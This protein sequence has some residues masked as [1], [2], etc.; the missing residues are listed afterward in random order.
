MAVRNL[1]AGAAALAQSQ[2]AKSLG[3]SAG[4]VQE[5]ARIQQ[6][7]VQKTNERRAVLRQDMNN[8]ANFITRMASL[9]KVSGQ[10]H[11]VLTKEAQ[12]TR[13][14]LNK[15]AAD[16]TLNSSEKIAEYSRLTD[17]YNALAASFSADQGKLS[18]FQANI[19]QG[20]TSEALNLADEDTAIARGLGTGN[21]EITKDGY[22]V[23][24][25]INGESKKMLV[26]SPDIDKYISKYSI[27]DL[28]GLTTLQ[29]NYVKEIANA[30]GDTQLE[31]II[32]KRFELLPVEDKLKLL[33][34]LGGN[35]YINY[36]DKETNELNVDYINAEFK[37][38]A[39][40]LTDQ[41]GYTPTPEEKQDL[42]SEM[43][44]KRAEDGI[45]NLQ[46]YGSYVGIKYAGYPITAM[47]IETNPDS[48]DLGRIKIIQRI[49]G[50]NVVTYRDADDVEFMRDMYTR[51]LLDQAEGKDER[52]RARVIANTYFDTFLE[53]NNEENQ[54]T[55]K[56]I[57][58][59]YEDDPKSL[60]E[61][62]KFFINNNKE[63]FPDIVE[64]Q[65]NLINTEKE[66]TT[67]KMSRP[68]KERLRENWLVKVKDGDFNKYLQ[69]N[70]IPKEGA[71]NEKTGMVKS[72][73]VNRP[74]FKEAFGNEYPANTYRDGSKLFGTMQSEFYGQD[75]VKTPGG[76]F[77]KR[78]RTEVEGEIESRRQ[79]LLGK[80]DKADRAKYFRKSSKDLSA[81]DQLA[82]NDENIPKLSAK[83]FESFIDTG[84]LDDKYINIILNNKD[85][86]SSTL[87][88][89]IQKNF[90]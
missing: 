48:E 62:D 71:I 36:I 56:D 77:T 72:T 52:N 3:F 16:K 14:A 34:D 57:N 49:G 13:D 41:F 22:N 81:Y 61:Q 39:A 67:T 37:K 79:E 54:E 5:A 51:K 85:K 1:I 26:K 10:Y 19:A 32:Q 70:N 59:K 24:Y 35:S 47:G 84:E 27:K 63:L 60:T 69:D 66:A 64:D 46:N 88:D 50:D 43:L 83:D 2:T 45:K 74:D 8:A 86:F 6:D 68:Q 87:I 80:A 78:T 53:I 23:S 89:L 15:I 25:D 33:V 90:K 76:R 11:N 18:E 21:Y 44:T 9:D 29:D 30:K 17:E 28:E 82:K 4:L 55:A 20:L 31:G 65:Q 7:I 12:T 42:F 40:G 58:K 73:I 38:Y 75:F